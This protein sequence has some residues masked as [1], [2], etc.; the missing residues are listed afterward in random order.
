MYDDRRRRPYDSFSQYKQTREVVPVK[1]VSGQPGIYETTKSFGGVGESKDYAMDRG[2]IV[3]VSKP[4]QSTRVWPE[5]R[6]VDSETYL[7][8]R[9]PF[10]APA[11]QFLRDEATSTTNYGTEKFLKGWAD[12]HTGN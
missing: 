7:D 11:K 5:D 8:P 3:N 9:K 1:P 6:G 10:L 2:T 4:V 12:T